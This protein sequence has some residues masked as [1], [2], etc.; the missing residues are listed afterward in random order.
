MSDYLGRLNEAAIYKTVGIQME[1]S[2]VRRDDLKALIAENESLRK[3]AKYWSEAHD[4]ELE[5]S[6][7]LIEEREELRAFIISLAEHDAQIAYAYAAMCSPENP[8]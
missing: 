2:M 4:R 7:Q 3:D 5:R 8:Y 6:A 1:F